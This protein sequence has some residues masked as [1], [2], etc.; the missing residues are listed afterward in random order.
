M[1]QDV[2]YIVSCQHVPTRAHPRVTRKRELF[3][4]YSV[5]EAARGDHVGSMVG[6]TLQRIA[7]A[8]QYGPRRDGFESTASPSARE[9]ANAAVQA[10]GVER[11][12]FNPLEF[13]C[14]FTCSRKRG[15]HGVPQARVDVAKDLMHKGKHPVRSGAVNQAR[16]GKRVAMAK[17]QRK[18]PAV[19]RRRKAPPRR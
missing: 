12:D 15:S 6:L 16:R 3:L 8:E 11:S 14:G 5:S 17:A 7:G 1:F 2:G 19:K 9:W 13:A 4:L 10:A 18:S